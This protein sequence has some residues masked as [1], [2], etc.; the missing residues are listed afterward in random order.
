MIPFEFQQAKPVWAAGKQQEKNLSFLFRAVLPGGVSPVLY[1]AGHSDY[2]VFVNGEFLAQGPARAG[3]GYFR[4][5][6]LPLK[7]LLTKA[8]NTVCILCA[9]YNVNSFYLT[10]QPPF[11]C[12]EIVSGA[13]VL[14]ATGSPREFGCSPFAARVQKVQRYSFQRPFTEAYKLCAT[15]DRVFTDVSFSPPV[16]PLAPA[17]EKKFLVR[18]TKRSDYEER[19]AKSIVN[20]GVCRRSAQS[21]KHF[22]DRSVDNIDN[23]RLK[24]FVPEE[25]EI[26]AVNE[27]YALD[28]A[29]QDAAARPAQPLDLPA[30][31]FAVYD[32]GLDTTGYIRL[33]VTPASDT[34]LWAVFNERLPSSGV[35]DPGS[36]SCANVVRWALEGGRTYRLLS[37]EPYTYRYLQVIIEGAPAKVEAVSQLCE[38]Y[39][40]AGL[41]KAPAF[42]DPAFGEIY[43]AAVETFRQNATDIFMDCPSRERGGWLCDSFFTSRT[44]RSVTGESHIEK[45][46][47]ENFIMEPSFSDLP[48]GMLPMCYPSDHPDGCYI[49]NWAMWYLLELKE[50]RERTGDDAMIAAA[51]DKMYA[52]AAFLKKYENE[53]GLLEKL[54]G[55]VFVEWSD[56]NDFVQDVNFPS[57]MLY[58]KFL[59]DLAALYGDAAVAAKAERLKE[60]VRSM[61]F[62]GTFF[63]DNAVRKQGELILTE[64]HTETAQYYAFFTGVASPK[65]HPALYR[66]MT[67]EFG[68]QRD[69]GTQY[70][71]VP[72][73]NAFIG[74]Y[75][76]LDIL[77]RQGDYERLKRE[78]KAF[79]LPMARATGTLWENMHSGA[80]CCHGFASHVACWLRALSEAGIEI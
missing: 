46:F 25:L 59:S 20:T 47:L 55:W 32:M 45:A 31:G 4:V 38:H 29:V 66:R 72:V 78:I 74:N 63:I 6:A 35:P 2:Q 8:Q 16:C 56:A 26:A 48:A 9:G 42:K 43:A 12:A 61:A 22:R 73:S 41:K 28:C 70:P 68:P 17:G 33:A 54:D 49:P 19:T 57:N 14:F 13:E 40:A 60:T 34:V 64:N 23:V 21:G 51:K 27:L 71:D 65:S 80:S 30:N 50:Y 15:Y 37:F 3:H 79:F 36:D 18:E 11:L 24:G 53:F 7:G 77:Y 10:D 52:L 62:N 44:E 69:P 1:A 58:A 39:P 75:L 76:R 67:E 5:D